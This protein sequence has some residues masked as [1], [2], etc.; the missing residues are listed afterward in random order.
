M[1]N[2]YFVPTPIGNFSDMMFRGVEILNN[3][4]EI[5]CNNIEKTNELLI[6]FNVK[7][8]VYCYKDNVNEVID[9]LN[10]GK[11]IAI[12]NDESYSGIDEDSTKIKEYAIKNNINIEVVPGANY[13]LT[14]LVTSGIPCDK[15]LYYGCLDK[16]R[17]KEELNSIIDFDRTIVF[18]ET[19]VTIYDTLKDLYNAFGKRTAVLCLNL[20]LDNESFIHFTLGDDIIVPETNKTIVLVVEGAKIDTKTKSLNEMS[21]NEHYDYYLKQGMDSKEAMK[22]VA[23][24]RG[25]SKSDIYKVVI[26]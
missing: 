15:F 22:K 10:K 6:H 24:D 4:D 18:Y 17:R 5:Y 14:G 3:S 26:K 21:I 11:V 1:T 8:E 2:L 23:K 25:V 19:Y 9:K 13:L 20:T 16:T 7:K 12:L